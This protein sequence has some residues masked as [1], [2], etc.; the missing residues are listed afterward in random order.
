MRIGYMLISRDNIKANNVV[1]DRKADSKKYEAVLIDFGKSTKAQLRAPPLYSRKRNTPASHGKCYLAPEVLKEGLYST[2]SDVYSLGIMLKS[3]SSLVGCYP[4]VRALVKEV[5]AE[6]PTT[7][8]RL[9]EF[10]QK[11]SAVKL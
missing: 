6:K 2:S 1:L 9:S 5:T 11:L 4:K 10:T 8:P 3:V 7:R